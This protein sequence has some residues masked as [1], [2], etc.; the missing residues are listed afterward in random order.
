MPSNLSSPITLPTPAYYPPRLLKLGTPVSDPAHQ[1][2]L[3]VPCVFRSLRSVRSLIAS[4]SGANLGR[5]TDVRPDDPCVY[6]TQHLKPKTHVSVYLITQF[7]HFRSN[8]VVTECQIE[9]MGYCKTSH[10]H[11]ARVLNIDGLS[12]TYCSV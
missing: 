9:D 8:G 4:A 1:L 5:T 2:T 10:G 6:C 3:R 12:R 11:D 7:Y